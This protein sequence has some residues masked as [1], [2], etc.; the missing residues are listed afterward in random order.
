TAVMKS[1][2]E[3]PLFSSGSALDY[4]KSPMVP[5]GVIYATRYGDDYLLAVEVELH[6][7]S[8]ARVRQKFIKYANDPEFHHV[9]Y[10]T[11]KRSVYDAYGKILKGLHEEIA[12]RIA[13]CLA[14]DLS[15]SGCDYLK[16]TYWLRGKTLEFND[17]F[18][19]KGK[20]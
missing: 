3:H 8:G 19:E 13:L 15:P 16:A 7:K 2:L 4:V 1:L 9:L 12:S 17:L 5:D 18:G 6:Q 14:P 10:V 20:E 11:Q